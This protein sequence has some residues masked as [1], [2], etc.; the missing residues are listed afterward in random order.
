MLIAVLA[1]GA[2]EKKEQPPDKPDTPAAHPAGI[3]PEPVPLNT[4]TETFPP[5]P[6]YPPTWTPSPAPTYFR[7]PTETPFPTYTPLPSSTPTAEV[8]AGA[9]MEG[10]QLIVTAK[11]A[12]L[13]N[14][15]LT[16]YQDAGHPTL[17][18]PPVVEAEYNGRIRIELVFYNDFLKEETRLDTQALLTVANGRIALDELAPTRQSDGPMITEQ[19][20]LSAL[21]IVTNGL[22]R[23]IMSQVDA[24]SDYLTL[25]TIQ[26]QPG[27]IQAVFAP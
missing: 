14:A 24:A 20:V 26:V 8:V 10:D 17:Q 23:A 7:P 11:N 6:T 21:E 27:Y 25:S 3:D 19:A 22:N 9:V 13:A 2:C 15:V 18:E 1:A 4:P 12:D 16:A 5:V